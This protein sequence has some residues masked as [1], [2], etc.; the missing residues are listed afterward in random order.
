MTNRARKIL[1]AIVVAMAATFGAGGA[2]QTVHAA[3]T[4][5]QCD[6]AWHS[7][8]SV[9]SWAQDAHG[10][11]YE[12][13][14]QIEYQASSESGGCAIVLATS[15]WFWST[16]D[17]GAVWYCMKS[18]RTDKNWGGEECAGLPL[19]QP[20]T[21]IKGGLAFSYYW[22]PT[23]PY[24]SNSWQQYFVPNNTGFGGCTGPDYIFQIGGGPQ[25]HLPIQLCAW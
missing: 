5:A 4:P 17:T 3:N 15:F 21:S 14:A 16:P 10:T 6:G 9:D 11:S 19:N 23:P 25:Y 22:Y 24:P 7:G 13:V 8:D 1:M 12:Y 20:L 18:Y 2:Q